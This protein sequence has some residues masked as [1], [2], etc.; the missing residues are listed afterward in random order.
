MFDILVM[1]FASFLIWFMF[2]GLFFLWIFRKKISKEQ[3]AH[4]LI[5]CF[6]S[7]MVAEII[8]YLFPTV[9]PFQMNGGGTLTLI[10]PFDSAFPSAH[11]SVSFGLATSTWMHDRR[12]GLA[13]LVGSFFVGLGRFFG[14][15]H[16]L[17]DVVAG[18]ML[19]IVSAYMVSG[20]RLNKLLK[21]GD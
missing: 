9:R 11:T 18:A 10:I 13:F 4:A 20:L 17:L 16:Y 19:G 7:W 3:V 5:A 21:R 15:V 8:K 14:N 1:F 2:G 12:V 6:I